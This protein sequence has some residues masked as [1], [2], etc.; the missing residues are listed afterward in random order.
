[1][2]FCKFY[3]EDKKKQLFYNQKATLDIFLE[4]GSI[5]KEQYDKSLT[6]L[7]EKMNIDLVHKVT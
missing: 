5:T 4:N 7:A 3:P 6:T 1:M 2:E